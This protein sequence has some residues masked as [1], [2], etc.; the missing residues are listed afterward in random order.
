MSQ[1]IDFKVNDRVIRISNPEKILWPD[2]KMTKLNFIQYLIEMSPYL[3]PYVKNRLLTTIRFPNGIE[4][5][6]FYQKNAPSYAPD[7]MATSEWNGTTYILLNDLPTLIWLGNQACLEY[8]V[9]FNCCDEHN[10]PSEIAFDLDPSDPNH[11]SLVLEV[12]LLVKDVLDSLGL[13]SQPKTS[14]ATGLQIYIPITRRYTYEQTHLFNRFVAFYM[15][16]KHPKL[17]TLERLVKNR[18]NKLYFDYLQHGKGKTL[19]APYFPRARKKGTVSAPVS[20]EE[21]QAGFHPHDFTM[22]NIVSRVKEKGDLFS[23]I[24]TERQEQSLDPILKE[25]QSFIKNNDK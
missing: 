20:W 15:A 18:G 4:A 22:Q 6:S 5:S 23:L 24:T 1:T 19:A 11:F 21:V 9:P 25:I 10:V 3:L 2:L 14:G 16:E 7:W 8:H 17:V 12:A 13:A